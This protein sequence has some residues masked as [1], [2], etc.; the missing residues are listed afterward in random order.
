MAIDENTNPTIK[1]KGII[2]IES[3]SLTNLKADTTKSIMDAF[4]TLLVE[5]HKISP[6]IT[7]S[8]FKG[9]PTMASKVF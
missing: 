5:P 3:G 1:A 6:K 7:S 8:T 9:V 4:I 2:N